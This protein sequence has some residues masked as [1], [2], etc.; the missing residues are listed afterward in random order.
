MKI[1]AIG[2]VQG[3]FDE[4]QQL[5]MLLDF[6]P[7]VDK[8]WFTGDLVNR[9]PKSLQVLRYVKSL[10]ERAITVLG[11]HDLHLLA[12][13]CGHGRLS[14]GDTLTPILEASDRDEL[15]RWL[16]CRPLCHFDNDLNCLL[17]HAGLPPQWNVVNTI[18][19][20][21]EVEAILRSGD[22]KGYF[23]KLYG[24]LPRFWHD[25]LVGWD[26][27]RYIT[28]ALTRLR[29]IDASDGFCLSAKGPIGTQPHGCQPWFD[30]RHRK[31]REST[32][33]FGHWSALGYYRQDKLIALDS[34]CLWGGALTAVDLTDISNP[35]Q[36]M[37]QIKCKGKRLP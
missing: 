24:D 13:A 26:R 4:L 10:G 25:S 34:G 22:Y 8:L 29:Y 17:I 12:I 28:N 23:S 37:F 11:N 7:K 6:N 16:R 33:V 15:L 18:A 3:C 36:R 30:A 9:G 35:S 32:I 19:Y 14:D 2:D 31:S 27:Y 5:I 20:A 1:F 21:R